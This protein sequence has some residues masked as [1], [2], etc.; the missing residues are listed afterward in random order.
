[1]KYK[2][3]DITIKN[4]N[5]WDRV[6]R[7]QVLAQAIL[8]YVG[9]STV[10]AYVISY[11]AVTAVTSWALNALAPKPSVGQ[12]GLLFNAREA[13]APQEIVYGKV[14]KGGYI[15]YA[16]TTG[17]SNKFLH[18]IIVLAGHEVNSIGQIYLN[19]EEITL[20]AD[21]YATGSRWADAGG[22]KKVYIRK[23]T[24]ADNQNVYTTLS[25]ITDGPDWEVNGAAPTNN[26]DTNFKG[27]GIACLYV[28]LAYDSNVFADGMPLFTAEVEGKKVY[29]P[30]DASTAYSANA[31]LC[32]RDYL[33]SAYGLDN[34]GDTDDAASASFDVAA[35]ACDEDVSL[36]GGGTEKRYEI[37]GVISLDR[38]P[39]DILGDMMTACAG[40]LFWGAGKWHLKVGEYVSPVKTLTLDDLRSEINLQTKHSRRDN[41][42]IVRGTFIDAEN[43]YIQADYPE[44]RSDVFIS[45]DSDVESA[46]DLTLPFTTSS[47]MAQRLAKM[48]LYRGRE[49]MTFTAD[50]GLEAFE[51]ECGDIISLTIDRYG[52]S[53]KEFEVVGWKFKNDGD[54]GDLRVALTLRETSSA[55]FS[56]SAEEAD[57]TSNNSTLP[58]PRAGL[59]I[60]NLAVSD[61]NTNITSDGT[62]TVTASLAWDDVDSAYVSHYLVGYKN[63]ATGIFAKSTTDDNTFET[64]LLVDGDSYTFVVEAVTDGGY[65]G[66]QQSVTF[67]AEADTT[68]P[69]TATSLSV[70]EG[71]RQNVVKWTNPTDN[72]FK[73]VEVYANTSNTSVG[74][75]LIGTVSG[76]EFVHSGLAQNTTRYYFVKT[77]DFTGN[78]SSFSTG[79]SGTT[80]ADPA[81]G[82]Q[83][84][85][86]ATGDTVI[87][88]R[89]YY[90][91]LQSGQPNAPTA[92]SYSVSTA[93]FT[94]LTTDWALTQ[95]QVDITDTSIKEW[96][97]A[98]TVTIDGGTSAQTIV[99]TTPTG[100]IQVNADIESDNYVAG[101]SGWKIERDTGFAEFGAAAIRGTLTVGQVPDLTA[102]KITDLG[103]LGTQDTVDYTT[104]VTNKPDLS[105]YATTAQLGTKNTVF[106]QPST[107]TPTALEDGDLWYQTD[108][109]EYHRWNG[110]AWVEVT[111]T[112]DSI[113]AGTIDANVVTVNNIDASNI[114]VGTLDGDEINIDNLNANNISAGTL[115]ADYINLTGSQLS[116]SGGVLVISAGGIG[117]T[118][119]AS[120][121]VNA[122]KIA[123][124]AV[125]ATQI[126][127]D[128]VTAAAMANNAVTEA[129]IAAGAITETKIGANAVTTAKLANSAVTADILAAGS[130]TTTKISDDAISTAKIAAGAITTSELAAG[131]VT[132]NEIAANTITA[133][134]IATGAITATE[135]AANS[136]TAAA[137]AANTITASE[138]ATGTITSNE[139]LA[140]TIQAGD[141]ASGTITANEI[142]TGTITANEIAGST[143]TG[144]KIVANT[145]TGGLLSTAGII[146]STA[147][148]DDGLI[149]NAKIANLSA[150]KITAGTISAARFIGSGITHLGSTAV[151][152]SA[153][154]GTTNLSVSIT[155]LQSGVELV[156]IAGVSGRSTTTNGRRTFTTTASLSGAG[157]SGS[158]TTV[159]GVGD[160]EGAAI[161]GWLGAVVTGTTTTTGTA[162]LSVSIVRGTGTGNTSFSG[163]IVI[164]GVQS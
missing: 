104:D 133:G 91:V 100:A 79:A 85:D 123:A 67:T 112:A 162:T 120:D 160:N 153:E 107:S 93:S 146:T 70:D 110:S 116:S 84:E 25:E 47:A 143:I 27:E 34:D 147:Q 142:A 63:N 10:A 92:T 46:L 89:V 69:A 124:D 151:S 37:N 6:P 88:G 90:Q 4:W 33:T 159:N 38:T 108:T 73:E 129:V 102:S 53:S 81:A 40:T 30:R 156:G 59:A 75:T 57:I 164:L 111:L 48:T 61:Q 114:T 42:N 77:K 68:A 49:Q 150:D 76:T 78:A 26:E 12:R 65:V 119:I 83:G 8:P 45:D 31:A 1:M 132:A 71:F 127:D 11:V 64:G 134:E 149:T 52:W 21:H 9:G 138:I 87:S 163:S 128:A 139:I 95:P 41:F 103:A 54:A 157:S 2:L 106:A 24:G 101:S 66:A 50:F 58:D 98:F 148:I 23:F 72:D 55:A 155:G 122:D 86:G 32:I 154:T 140:N 51:V 141:I 117:S 14:R 135:L 62:H 152:V 109:L 145:I 18:Q 74:A 22:Q 17:S 44:I 60:S 144:N 19:D 3:G 56:W 125:T 115:T 113:V 126:A 121:A 96:S 39:S 94:G 99:F 7:V 137:I 130:I 136:V 82:Q 36:S 158:V 35:D 161:G 20:G 13:A 118:E 5:S 97:S 80:L 15:T 29:D 131:A 105:A 28:R 43:R 16:E